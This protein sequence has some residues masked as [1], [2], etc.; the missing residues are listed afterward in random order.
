MVEKEDWGP[1]YCI[2]GPNAGRIG[3]YDDDEIDDDR[4]D[5][6]MELIGDDDEID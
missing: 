5:S 4:F 1:V 2:D 6:C 3:Y